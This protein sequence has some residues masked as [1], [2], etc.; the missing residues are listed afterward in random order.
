MKFGHACYT[1]TMFSYTPSWL[2][3]L[4][5]WLYDPGLAVAAIIIISI[6]LY[7]VAGAIVAQ[8]IRQTVRPGPLNSLTES[9]AHKRQETLISLFSALMKFLVSVTAVLLLIRQLF[10]HVDLTPIFAS[11][12]IVGIALGFGAQSIVR[13]FFSGFFIIMENQYR[14]GDTVDIEGA[15]GTV[16]RI[17]IRSTVLRDFDGNV[18]FIPNGSIVKV[19]NK[20]MGF[21]KANLTITVKPDSD[22]DKVKRIINRVGKK[23]AKEELWIGKIIDPPKFWNIGNFSDVSLD[24]TIVTTTQPSEQWSVAGELRMRLLEEFAQNGIEL[25]HTPA[26]LGKKAS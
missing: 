17:T 2:E 8:L 23:M 26:G 18:H 12:G 13:D 14:V 15:A 5:E 22:V 20:T 10:P 3:T 1:T 16:E 6:V 21:S 19:V 9:D 25:A 11:A 4:A 24:V 7:H